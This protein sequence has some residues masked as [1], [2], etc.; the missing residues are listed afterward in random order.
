M[1][2]D[3]F[4]LFLPG[5]LENFI[6]SLNLKTFSI[7]VMVIFFLIESV[8]CSVMTTLCDPM[9]CSLLG[10]PVHEILQERILEWV[11]IPFSGASSQRRDQTW[12]SRIVGRFFTV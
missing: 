9:D 12:V 7:Y 4:F 8:S 6:Y 10:S 3:P 2:H 5:Y 11:V 1:Q